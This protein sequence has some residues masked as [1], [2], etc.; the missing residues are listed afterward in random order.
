MLSRTRIS[1]STIKPWRKHWMASAVRPHLSRCV[2]TVTLPLLIAVSTYF[3]T[4]LNVRYCDLVG[5]MGKC[6]EGNALSLMSVE[7][8]WNHQCGAA[9]TAIASSTHCGPGDCEDINV[10]ICKPI[11][12]RIIQAEWR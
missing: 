5:E 7:P 1:V 6:A 8:L 11:P 10:S 2:R 9:L 12:H 3:I 4:V